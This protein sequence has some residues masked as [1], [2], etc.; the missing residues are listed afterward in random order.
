MSTRQ[1]LEWHGYN[2]MS[3]FHLHS[4]KFECM[5]NISFS[6][7]DFNSWQ[8]EFWRIVFFFS[9]N[10]ML[11]LATSFVSRFRSVYY[12]RHV[13]SFSS[14]F[15]LDKIQWTLYFVYVCTTGKTSTH[16][17]RPWFYFLFKMC[18]R[19]KKREATAAA[20]SA[21]LMYF[22]FRCSSRP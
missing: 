21:R 11:A 9:S 8:H 2:P 6:S 5:A 3:E 22:K 14:L 13:I 17:F 7:R 10:K 18:T 19:K 1:S 4:G 16:W 15:Q 20:N 12:I